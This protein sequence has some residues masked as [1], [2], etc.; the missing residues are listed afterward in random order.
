MQ[1]DAI[2]RTKVNLTVWLGN[3][4]VPTNESVYTR[5]RDLILNALQ[6]YG[7]DHVG[8]VTVGNEFMLKCVSCASF[9]P[10]RNFNPA[11]VAI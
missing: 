10:N 11:F 4:P 3:Y 5:Q 1:L 8:G 6:T 7:T 9:W 2:Q